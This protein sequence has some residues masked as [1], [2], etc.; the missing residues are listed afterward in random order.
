MSQSKL[1]WAGILFWGAI[2]GIIGLTVFWQKDNLQAWLQNPQLPNFST[3]G[4]AFTLENITTFIKDYGFLITGATTA[5]TFVYGFYQKHQ[6]SVANIA[7]LD[8]EQASTKIELEANSK[9]ASAQ[10][11]AADYK[12]KYENAIGDSSILDDLKSTVEGK[13]KTIEKLR[14]QMELL[15]QQN[16]QL[17]DEIIVGTK[18]LETVTVK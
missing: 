10:S 16:K 18:I 17:Q 1:N 7:K 11:L 6:A 14:S 12:Q 4:K 9:I 5:I 8:A 15:N 3:I 13:D 2:I